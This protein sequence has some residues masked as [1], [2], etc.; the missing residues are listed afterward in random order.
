MAMNARSHF[1]ARVSVHVTAA[2]GSPNDVRPGTQ[3][4]RALFCNGPGGSSGGHIPEVGLEPTISPA[5][6]ASRPGW[7]DKEDVHAE[8]GKRSKITPATRNRTRDHLIAAGVYSQM[9]YQLSYS[10]RCAPCTPSNVRSSP[11]PRKAFNGDC[12]FESC[13]GHLG[14]PRI[15]ARRV[16]LHTCGA[17]GGLAFNPWRVCPGSMCLRGLMAKVPPSDCLDWTSNGKLGGNAGSIPAAGIAA[18][19][20]NHEPKLARKLRGRELNPGLPRD[21]RKY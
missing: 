1:M 18:P 10:R 7:C 9:L 16:A 20:R 15:T 11:A 4:Q 6:A 5:C 14:H 21:R 3:V 2:A 17:R 19:G 12:R 13:R 8:C